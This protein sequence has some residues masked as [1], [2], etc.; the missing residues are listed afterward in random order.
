M[1]KRYIATCGVITF[2]IVSAARPSQADNIS[3]HFI[4]VKSESP[5]QIKQNKMLEEAHKWYQT[6]YTKSIPVVEVEEMKGVSNESNERSDENVSEQ[7][8]KRG[9]F[10]CIDE[11]GEETRNVESEFS[12]GGDSESVGGDSAPVEGSESEYEADDYTVPEQEVPVEEPV[13]E[14][15][16]P[17][18]EPVAEPS[19]EY[20]GDWTISFYCPCSE[21]CG[22]WSGGPT[23]SGAMPSPWYTVATGDLP[24]GTMLY[25][26]G[27]GTFEVQDR[28]TGYGWA[29]VFVSDHGEALENGLQTRAVYI[30]R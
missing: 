22:V 4:N 8:F 19:M 7:V 6:Q 2:L 3:E 14:I 24:F 1:I 25:I 10:E 27:L 15:P 20:L 21:C 30:V 29:D 16:A 28:G 23:A 11:N 9:N 13:E 26:D 5:K 12:A 18:P 17:E